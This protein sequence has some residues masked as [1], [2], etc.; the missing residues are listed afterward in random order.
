VLTSSMFNQPSRFLDLR[1][2]WLLFTFNLRHAENSL[3]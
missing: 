2:V 3:A 1:I